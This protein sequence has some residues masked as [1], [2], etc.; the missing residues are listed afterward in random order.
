MQGGLLSVCQR[1]NQVVNPLISK[2][3]SDG[4][5]KWQDCSCWAS[6]MM[7]CRQPFL[8]VCLAQ[9]AQLR[10]VIILIYSLIISAV[11]SIQ[12][13]IKRKLAMAGILISS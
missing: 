5:T 1:V 11:V 7:I 8:L 3:S 4:L 9:T 10:H 6:G 13:C 12:T 2:L